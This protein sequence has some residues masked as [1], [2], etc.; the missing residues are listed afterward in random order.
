M[1]RPA[2]VLQHAPWEGPG[3][4]G[5]ALTAAGVSVETRTVVDDP[6]AA[7]PD[8][9]DLAAL[10]VMGG[11]MGATQDAAHPGL[12]AERVLLAAAAR[13]GIPVLGVCLGMQL[14]AVALGARLLPGHGAEV[15]YAPIDRLAPDPVLDRLGPAPSVLHWHDDAVE[16]PPGATLLARSARTPVQAFRAGS[17]L[18]LQF[19]PEVDD[20]LLATWLSTPA[21]VD[22]LVAH[23]VT[24]LP[25]QAA[26]VLP[27]AVPAARGGLA[28]F[29]ASARARG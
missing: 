26:A 10:V 9:E 11:P 25:A 13:A 29:A 12:P 22:D 2:L 8:P 23:G 24:D 5:E 4:I 28:H 3:L 6:A 18:G 21:M 17:A 1:S 15:G 20:T 14:L 19:H 7:L 27:T 16:L